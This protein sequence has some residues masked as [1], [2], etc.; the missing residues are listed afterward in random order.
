M[1]KVISSK[2][3]GKTN[4]SAERRRDVFPESNM[5]RIIAGTFLLRN[6]FGNGAWSG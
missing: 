2:V 1:I 3:T 6:G 5:W 4:H